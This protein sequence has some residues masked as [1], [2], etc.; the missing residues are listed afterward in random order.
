MSTLTGQTVLVIG[1]SSG[2]GYAVAKLSLLSDASRV[3]IAS[4]S[5]TKVDNALSRLAKDGGAG[6]EKRIA[7][8]TVDSSNGKDVRALLER[9]GEIDHLVYTSGGTL[10]LG[11]PDVNLDSQ[12]GAFTI[13]LITRAHCLSF[14]S[15]SLSQPKDIFDLMFWGGLEAAKAAKLKKGG[16]I[17]LTIGQSIKRPGKGWTLMASVAGA[18]DAAARGLAVDLAPSRVNIVSPGFVATEVRNL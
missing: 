1:G 5:K 9:V 15:T 17:T 11:F 16:S 4:S 6:A 13:L 14:M 7:G 12:K 8:E 18:A 10:R 2:I 3:I